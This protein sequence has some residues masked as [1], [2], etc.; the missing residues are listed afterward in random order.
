MTAKADRAKELL[1]DPVLQDAFGIVK[2][3]LL[4]GFQMLGSADIEAMQEIHAKLK[5]LNAVE[6]QLWNIVS[7]GTLE[8]FRAQEQERLS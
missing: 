7:D 6:Q 1:N 5:L 4:D 3:N 2:Q 8:D